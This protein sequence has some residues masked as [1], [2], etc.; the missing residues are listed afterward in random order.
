MEGGAEVFAAFQIAAVRKAFDSDL[1]R[2]NA[3]E[4]HWSKLNRDLLS[5]MSMLRIITLGI[6]VYIYK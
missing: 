4:I 2:E 3:I 6:L 1:R 5:L